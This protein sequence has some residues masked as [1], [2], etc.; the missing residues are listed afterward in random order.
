MFFTAMDML[1]QA[2]SGKHFWENED[3]ATVDMGDGRRWSLSKQYF[4]PAKW[5]WKPQQSAMNKLATLPRSGI[6]FMMGQ[7]YL[8][9]GGMGPP[10]ENYATW[11][12]KKALP[13][14]GQAAFQSGPAAGLAG[15]AGFPIYG[16]ESSSSGLSGLGRKW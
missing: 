5:L 8:R 6:E 4:E 15:M 14:W 11:A 7:E 9:H 12:A 3:P 13:I 2:F 1:N 10:I 16:E